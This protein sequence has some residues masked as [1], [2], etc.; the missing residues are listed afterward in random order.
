[1]VRTGGVMAVLNDAQT[2]PAPMAAKSPSLTSL[3]KLC[4][5]GVLLRSSETECSMSKVRTQVFAVRT[6]AF[7]NPLLPEKRSN[8]P[9]PSPIASSKL[10]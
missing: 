10:A 3:T 7:E 2:G 6:I 5:R 8:T 9:G 1:M 4:W